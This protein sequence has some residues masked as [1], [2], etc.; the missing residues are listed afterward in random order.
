M[1]SIF[2]A[3]TKAHFVSGRDLLSQF[4]R[5]DTITAHE[6]NALCAAAEAVISAPADPRR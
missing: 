5:D 4:L 2:R 1:Q 3:A 6:I